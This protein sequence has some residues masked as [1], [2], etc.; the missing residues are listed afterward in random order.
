MMDES[1][2]YGVRVREER[3]NPRR[4]GAREGYCK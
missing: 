3:V 2:A 4:M 1:G